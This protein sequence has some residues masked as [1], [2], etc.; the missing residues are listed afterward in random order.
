MRDLILMREAFEIK[1]FGKA[2]KDKVIIK[3]KG[4]FDV[5]M[6]DSNENI[7][8]L[9]KAF[10]ERYFLQSAFKAYEEC[11]HSGAKQILMKV[12]KLHMI[13]YLC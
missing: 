4:F 11:S 10:G 2:L 7:Q 6:Y 12:L 8:S 13:D 5:W 1:S 9:A 3:E